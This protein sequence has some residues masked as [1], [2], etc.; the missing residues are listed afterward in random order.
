MFDWTDILPNGMAAPWLSKPKSTP[1]E[2]FFGIAHLQSFFAAVGVGWNAL[3]LPPTVVDVDT[4]P[5]PNGGAS[6]LTTNVLPS[7]GDYGD[8]HGSVVTDLQT[9]LRSDGT[10]L[11]SELWRYLIGATPPAV[12]ALPTTRL[13]MKDG[14][15]QG[16]ASRR[17]I[18]FRAKTRSSP[19]A[20][21]VVPPVRGGD[22]DPTLHGALLQVFNASAGV[23][24]AKIVL[25]S[26]GWRSLGS[27]SAPR[28]FRFD[29]GVSDAA[30][31]RVVVQPDT[32]I[33]EGGGS[34]W[35]YSLDEPSQ[36][37]VGMRLTLGSGIEWCAEAPAKSGERNDRVDRFMAQPKTSPPAACPITARPL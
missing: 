7:S 20:N 28:G 11:L 19:T 27:E 18:K 15:A 14:S 1:A 29:D 23:E 31:R 4:T 33:I 35:C 16:D 10:P 5:E 13:S 34:S 9:P 12:V 8:A 32:L 17:K 6:R 2:R 24:V 25:P 26:S 30:I 21:R 36:G 22:G 37:R 3:G